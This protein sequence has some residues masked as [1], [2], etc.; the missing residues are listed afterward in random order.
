MTELKKKYYAVFRGKKPGIYTSWFGAGGAEEQVRGFPGA[1]YRGFPTLQEANEYLSKG[2]GEPRHAREKP[3]EDL[4][5]SFPFKGKF[6]SIYTDGGCINN[7]GPGGYG[8]VII[9][10]EERIELTGGF[11]LTT[12]NR[13]ELTAC[14]VALRSLEK[15][16]RAVLTTDSRYVVNG[17]EKGW[18]KKWRAKNW[19]R[20]KN[21]KAENSD[22]WS[23]LLDVLDKHEVSFQWV[24]GHSGHPE[25]ER[26]DSLASASALLPD[27][28]LDLGYEKS[29]QQAME[30]RLF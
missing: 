18:A 19:M 24:R 22:L 13:M 8:I 4:P 6:I 11:R 27:L 12:N 5:E 17:I 1:V 7:P 2:T 3:K 15:S 21:H 20:D 10:D 26:C 14:I 30:S 28:P 9:D 29:R 25:N 23:E 16:S